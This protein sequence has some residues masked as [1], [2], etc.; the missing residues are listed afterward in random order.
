MDA[1]ASCIHVFTR[2]ER[3]DYQRRENFKVGE[4]LA[5]YS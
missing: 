3:G 2:P 5:P 1:E 4:L